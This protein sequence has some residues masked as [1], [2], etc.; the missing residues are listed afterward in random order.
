MFGRASSSGAGTGRNKGAKRTR[1]FVDL[2]AATAEEDRGVADRKICTTIH[3]LGAGLH[4]LRALPILRSDFIELSGN[5]RS[6]LDPQPNSLTARELLWLCLCKFAPSRSVATKLDRNHHIHAAWYLRR[7]EVFFTAADAVS[8][9]AVTWDSARVLYAILAPPPL[10]SGGSLLVA[11]HDGGGGGTS[12]TAVPLDVALICECAT[13]CYWVEYWADKLRTRMAPL[14]DVSHTD[15]VALDTH[16][17]ATICSAEFVTM[18]EFRCRQLGAKSACV[19]DPGST[20][21]RFRAR[22]VDWDARKCIISTSPGDKAAQDV[23][24]VAEQ[25]PTVDA[26]SRPGE[27]SSTSREAWM[28]VA[29]SY[30][31]SQLAPAPATMPGGVFIF[32][33]WYVV[34]WHEIGTARFFDMAGF[35]CNRNEFVGQRPFLVH[36]GLSNWVVVVSPS[37]VIVCSGLA[38]ALCE[39]TA[40]IHADFYGIL[41]T[42]F[43]VPKTPIG[44]LAGMGLAPS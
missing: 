35:K 42:T 43:H 28:T 2:A 15:V 11:P 3:E 29:W 17:R 19:L 25:S 39:W 21:F 16:L 10:P 32:Q 27:Y 31:F 22:Q 12:T 4:H 44:I 37:A 18:F 20:L 40:R 36:L 6:T 33:D 7:P 41:E 26:L 38:H 34:H 5:T 8:K 23:L 1:V 30:M 24:R 13:A 14:V 9:S